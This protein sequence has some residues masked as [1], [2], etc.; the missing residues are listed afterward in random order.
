MADFIPEAQAST[1]LSSLLLVVVGAHL[2]AEVADRPLA[3]GL[4]DRIRSWI[5]DHGQEMNV[6]LE[7]VVCSDVWYINNAPLQRRPTISVG[8]PG[9]NAL[10]AYYADK[11]SSALVHDNHLVI[12]LDPELVD[13]RVSLWG[14]DHQLTVEA[15][16]VFI[17]KYLTPYLRAVVT[18]V[19]PSEE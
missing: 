1:D 18:Q 9:V 15:M 8:G 3:Y 6:P 17:Q 13:L 5:Q 7:P 4:C 12:Q 2:R 10:S 14:M 11:L 19:E 16:K